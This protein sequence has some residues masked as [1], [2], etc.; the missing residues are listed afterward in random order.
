MSRSEQACSTRSNAYEE[1]Y[2]LRDSGKFYLTFKPLAYL[3]SACFICT[4]S[5]IRVKKHLE[6][7]INMTYVF[8]SYFGG[9][10][11]CCLDSSC[12]FLRA[13]G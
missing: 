5:C 10:D 4:S 6:C 12:S 3:V 7:R 9:Q 1:T 11:L 2:G 8:P 13:D